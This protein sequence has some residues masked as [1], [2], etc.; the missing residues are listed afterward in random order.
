MTH[1]YWFSSVSPE[2]FEIVAAESVGPT[3]PR[4]WIKAG[5]KVSLAWFARKRV[6]YQGSIYWSRLAQHDRA[7]VARRR[8]PRDKGTAR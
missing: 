5:E 3:E 2:N 6:L 4:R 8:R 7:V 1:G